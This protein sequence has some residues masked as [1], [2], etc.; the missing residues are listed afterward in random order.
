MRQLR[1]ALT[2]T[3]GTGK[4]YIVEKVS[5][6][7]VAT[8]GKSYEQ[9]HSPT[10]YVKSLGFRNNEDGQW[11]TQ[12]LS[13]TERVLRQRRA[14]QQEAPLVLADRCLND[15]LAYNTVMLN[16]ISESEREFLLKADHLLTD[17][18][19]GDVKNY[20]DVVF[21]KPLHPKF[22][23][24]TDGD[25]SGAVSFQQD[26]Q[27]AAVQRLKDLGVQYVQLPEDRDEAA[28]VVTKWILDK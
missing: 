7:F 25:R 21:Y 10:R 4:T 28:D 27:N 9:V 3:H 15:E 19:L 17:F 12:L 26:V 20:W 6:Q 1:V 22:L 8:T 16:T 23:P 13:G 24:E 18:W 11:Q 2:G 14:A 5:S